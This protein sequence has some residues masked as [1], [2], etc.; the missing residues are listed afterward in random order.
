MLI[1]IAELIAKAHLGRLSD[2]EAEELSRWEA[3]K[4]EHK[5]WRTN[6]SDKN[7]ASRLL[8]EYRALEGATEESL[9][10]FHS[11]HMDGAPVVD[12]KTGRRMMT[13]WWA[14][15]A[16]I[17][18][19]VVAGIWVARRSTPRQVAAT[20]PQA[21]IKPGRFTATLT[22][23][24]GSHVLL[25]TGMAGQLVQK[26]GVSIVYKDGQVDY[27]QKDLAAK[28]VVYNTLTTGKGGQYQVVL[29]DGTKAWLNAASSLRY[30]TAFTGKERHVELTGEAYF[31]VSPRRDQPFSVGVGDMTIHVLGTEFDVMAYPDEEGKKTTLVRGAVKVESR[32]KTRQLAVGDQAIV[33]KEGT[34]SVVSQVDVES[35]IAWKFGFFQFSHMDIKT[36]MREIARW[37]DVDIAYQR[38]NLSGEYGGR[39]SRNLNLSELISLLEGNGVGHFKIEGRKLIVLP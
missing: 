22:L 36:L 31:D 28:E 13:R 10:D 30:P 16:V 32:S 12:I 25:D 34:I 5:A 6:L 37:Y 27:H 3:E 7:Y 33:P 19:L 29:P 18:P 20:A 17:L 2:A 8:E 24:N 21:V 1:R 38:Q 39:I 11:R 14:A 9:Q 23:A 4:E 26:G 35:V 15:A